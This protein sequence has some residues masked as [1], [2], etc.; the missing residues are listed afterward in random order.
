MIIKERNERINNP[1]FLLEE[2]IREEE[3]REA[4]KG[5]DLEW[6]EKCVKEMMQAKQEFEAY[7]GLKNIQPDDKDFNTYY[8]LR[9]D[10]AI[11][12]A[13]CDYKSG[14]PRVYTR[15]EINGHVKNN[16]IVLNSISKRRIP[17]L[18]FNYLI[19]NNIIKEKDFEKFSKNQFGRTFESKMG[20]IIY[21]KDLPKEENRQ[22]R[23]TK[24]DC[25]NFKNSDF[26]GV[27][28]ISNQWSEDSIEKFI[29]YIHK[30][31]GEYIEITSPTKELMEHL[32]LRK[33]NN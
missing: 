31:Y 3:K 2:K 22:K 25:S 19:W 33:N 28:Y 24:L 4:Q 30:N 17:E 7:T 1:H 5:W 6:K 21:E 11:K 8:E 12:F 18:V 26:H 29:D 10:K 9:R 32:K 13:S 16:P 15:Y 27:I 20:D 23:Y 14:N